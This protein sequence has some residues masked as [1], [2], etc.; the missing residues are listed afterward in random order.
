MSAL[1]LIRLGGVG[2]HF[3]VSLLFKVCLCC[4]H[5]CIP[6]LTC[7]SISPPPS[8]LPFLT[9]SP[10]P[11]VP[12][13]SA[14]FCSTTQPNNFGFVPGSLYFLTFPFSSF[15]HSFSLGCS[16]LPL[17]SCLPLLPFSFTLR[18]QLYITSISS[19]HPYTLRPHLPSSVLL[20]HIFPSLPCSSFGL[21]LSHPVC[22]TS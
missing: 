5:C 16:P 13:L 3:P 1:L 4:G 15:P 17:P 14:S 11:S 22:L 10:F 7:L 8:F 9:S 18:Q 6:T 19:S 2:V 20:S 21:C 12:L